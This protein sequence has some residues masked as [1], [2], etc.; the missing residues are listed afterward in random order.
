M[1]SCNGDDTM[2]R[3]RKY[4]F[5]GADDP[6]T[7]TEFLKEFSKEHEDLIR[8]MIFEKSARDCCSSI[9][10]VNKKNTFKLPLPW[11]QVVYDNQLYM[12]LNSNDYYSINVPTLFHI[13]NYDKSI[14][15]D[16]RP[17]ILDWKINMA[18]KSLLYQFITW[19]SMVY[20]VHKS[21]TEALL[22]YN[23]VSATWRIHYPPQTITG[24]S[25]TFNPSDSQL[26]PNE[27]LLVDLHSHHT[28]TIGFS[29]V[30][31]H[32]DKI[33]GAI[34]HISIVLKMIDRINFLN[35]DNNFDVRL[36][37][38]GI[39][40]TLQLD[41]VFVD[42]I[43]YTEIMDQVIDKEPPVVPLPKTPTT[44]LYASHSNINIGS[45]GYASFSK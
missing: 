6:N 34:S 28:M 32:S 2:G 14:E 15:L 36:T 31:D 26:D 19:A 25:V 9:T 22:I 1:D 38:Q 16:M 42:D 30:D 13:I 39:S 3:K 40:Y 5:N 35:L 41:D 24:A 43:D 33:L 11:E 17:P 23:P 29:A 10:T 7:S 18:P 8:D 37:V 4:S 45:Y 27:V 20:N 44:S 12:F 21:E